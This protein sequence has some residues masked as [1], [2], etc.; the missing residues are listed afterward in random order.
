MTVSHIF[1]SSSAKHNLLAWNSTFDSSLF[2]VLM[3]RS[4]L[5]S[6]TYFSRVTL[7]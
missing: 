5:Q 3:S 2:W 7:S 6:M 4:A 1:H